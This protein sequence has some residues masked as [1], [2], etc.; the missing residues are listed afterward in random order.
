MNR[1][2]E[3]AGKLTILSFLFFSP[4]ELIGEDNLASTENADIE[5]I[6]SD[7]YLKRW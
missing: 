6:Y 7:N 4:L 1:F 3:L 5:V 2:K